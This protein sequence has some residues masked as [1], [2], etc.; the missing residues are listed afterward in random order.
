MFGFDL[1]FGLCLGLWLGLCSVMGLVFEFGLELVV[2]GLWFWAWLSLRFGWC[3]GLGLEMCLGF[4][5]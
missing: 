4:G 1:V 3:L 2:L 5:V